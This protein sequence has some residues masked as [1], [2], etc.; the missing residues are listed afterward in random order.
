MY[1][2]P[3]RSYRR[4]G[5]WPWLVCLAIALV[6]GWWLYTNQTR[7]ITWVGITL[8]TP[9]PTEFP[10]TE[11]LARGDTALTLGKYDDA[12]ASYQR[13]SELDPSLAT[14]YARFC[15]LYTSDAA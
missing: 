6:I 13:A 12:I 15:L 2:R 10:A 8:P 14:A 4:R 5:I 9:A 3:A 1:L 7:I 11:Y